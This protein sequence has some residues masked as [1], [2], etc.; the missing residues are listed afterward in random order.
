MIVKCNTD[1]TKLFEVKDGKI[2]IFHRKT[3]MTIVIPLEKLN[4]AII[5]GKDILKV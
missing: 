3:K 5:Q 2:E 4:E 1:G